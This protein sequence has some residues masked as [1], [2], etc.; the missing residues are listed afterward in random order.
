MDTLRR[1]APACFVYFLPSVRLK[2]GGEDMR[3]LL[4]APPFLPWFLP[5][6][7]S[8]SSLFPPTHPLMGYVVFP[9]HKIFFHSSTKHLLSCLALLELCYSVSFSMVLMW[10]RY[11][12]SSLLEI[13]KKKW[14]IHLVLF[15]TN[16]LNLKFR[17]TADLL[18]SCFCDFTLVHKQAEMNGLWD[19]R[20]AL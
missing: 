13:K 3:S 10:F 14:V 7:P 9:R 6:C 8:P 18:F 12:S 17:G 4:W 20:Q 19:P 11:H 1:F 2:E 16:M 15:I 5:R